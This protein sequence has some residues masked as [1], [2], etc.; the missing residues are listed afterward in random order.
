MSAAASIPS[1]TPSAPAS[2]E[3]SARANSKI[4][5]LMKIYGVISLVSGATVLAGGALIIWG[6]ATGGIDAVNRSY[7]VTL[8][9]TLTVIQLVL[10]FFHSVTD[11][12]FG[13]SLLRDRRRHAALYAYLLVLLNIVIGLITIMLLGF[14]G[15]VADPLIRIAILLVIAATVDPSLNRERELAR[16]RRDKELAQE[17]A[18]GTLGRAKDGRGFIELNF[19]NLFWVFTVCCVIGLIIETIYHMVIVD[20]GHY[21]DRAG[22]LFGPFSPIY[23]FGATLMTIALNRF[24]KANPLIIF[25]VSAVIGGAFEA[26]TSWF[27]EVSFGAVA[28]DY[29]GFTIFG[30]FPDPI[31]ELTGGRTSTL[32]M[33]MWGALG[34]VW[35]KFCLPWLL[36]LINRIPWQ[37]RYAVT[38]VCALLMLV[39]GVMTLQS[40]ECWY[41]R[42]SGL[43]PNSPVEVFYAKHFDNAYMQHRFQSMTI[44]PEKTARVPG[45][46][47]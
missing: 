12:T 45:A 5:L 46:A 11:V 28:W 13:I 16:Q 23:G 14:K 40:L 39:N 34:F 29:S 19:F 30:L 37:W 1:A 44:T 35:I 24:Y 25:L 27:M 8:T 47:N 20:P 43:Q 31:A 7:H 2:A 17:A 15:H 22:M 26:A 9:V 21:Q 18:A 33:C 4:P 6:L 3:P 38:T 41:D 32:F 42:E 36:R 10:V